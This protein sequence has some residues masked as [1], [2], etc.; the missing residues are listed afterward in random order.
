VNGQRGYQLFEHLELLA[1]EERFD[2]IREIR[3]SCKATEG[4]SVVIVTRSEL[5]I[6]VPAAGL[7]F[8]DVK[9]KLSG[10]NYLPHVIEPSFG[11]G[12]IIYAVLEHG[13]WIRPDSEQRKVISFRPAISPVKCIVLPLL[14]RDIE[15]VN[16]S[17]EIAGMLSAAGIS[18]KVDDGGQ[19]VGKRYSRNDEIGVPFAVTIDY[20]SVHV[21]KAESS[22]STSDEKEVD[23]TVT[24]RERDTCVQFRIHASE[25]VAL[26]GQLADERITWSSAVE[27]NKHNLITST[28]E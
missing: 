8:S 28:A 10:R 21:K 18:C 25:L 27:A 15:L 12:R 13:F 2:E 1:K 6:T 14:T 22:S 5:P 17:S 16:K 20:K 7:T 26:V 9:I 23:G 3:E 11:I 4:G 19:S 24:L